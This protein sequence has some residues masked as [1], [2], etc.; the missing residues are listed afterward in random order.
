MTAGQQAHDDAIDYFSIS[1][2]DLRNFLFDLLEL[3][4]E[5]DDLLING[6]T[7]LLMNAPTFWRAAGSLGSNF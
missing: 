4:L 5:R 3:F 6:D 2:D 7:H 1:D